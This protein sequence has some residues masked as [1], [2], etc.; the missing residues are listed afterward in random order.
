MEKLKS[1][2][3]GVPYWEHAFRYHRF[4]DKAKHLLDSDNISDKAVESPT[5]FELDLSARLFRE[6]G[7]VYNPAQYLQAARLLLEHGG[8]HWPPYQPPLK[9]LSTSKPKQQPSYR[10]PLKVGDALKAVVFGIEPFGIFLR[11]VDHPET[12]ILVKV[13]EVSWGNT[14]SPAEFTQM[15]AVLPIRIFYVDSNDALAVTVDDD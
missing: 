3:L 2:V 9:P 12:D 13:T 7:G 15:G 10:R 8:Q 14:T 1:F 6:F 4:S 11:S 5:Q